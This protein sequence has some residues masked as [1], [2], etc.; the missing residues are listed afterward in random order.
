VEE[1]D[2]GNICT[3][4]TC[5]EQQ[6]CVHL[7]A[8]A[9][10][11]CYQPGKALLLI[12]DLP[13]DGADLLKWKWGKGEIFPPALFGQPD[14]DTDYA[15]CIFD[16]HGGSAEL[17]GAYYVPADAAFWKTRPNTVKY[18]NKDAPVDGIVTLKAKSVNIAGKSKAG[19]KAGGAALVLPTPASSNLYFFHEPDLVAQLRNTEGAC[20]T[21]SF[22]ASDFKKNGGD[23]VKA[24]F[25]H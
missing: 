4:D 22:V 3:Y 8:V 12:K 15:L 10:E 19:L 6:G 25:K 21:T 14:I 23:K 18:V 20:W 9:D 11:G 24:V 1:C 2:D 13:V 16:N 5:D 17:V 7:P